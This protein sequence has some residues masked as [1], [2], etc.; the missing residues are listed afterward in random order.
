M[1]GFGF[2]LW[3]ASIIAV[4][5]LPLLYFAVLMRLVGRIGSRCLAVILLVAAALWATAAFYWSL[6]TT[7]T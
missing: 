3:L 1:S 7:R 2:L 6:V 4:F 5:S